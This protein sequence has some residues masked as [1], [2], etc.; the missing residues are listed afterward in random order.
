MSEVFVL[1]RTFVRKYFRTTKIK[2]RTVGCL[3]M[4]DREVGR[5]SKFNKHKQ[6]EREC[7]ERNEWS[8]YQIR[9]EL[10]PGELQ[11]VRPPGTDRPW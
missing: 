8:L 4:S 3:A 10:N 5:G 1:S 11:T 2:D 6:C 9:G 7:V